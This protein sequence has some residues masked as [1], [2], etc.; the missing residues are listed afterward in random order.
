MKLFKFLLFVGL[1]CGILSGCSSN[2]MP[3]KEAVA[4]QIKERLPEFVA[5]DSLVLENASEKGKEYTKINFKLEARLTEDLF[6]PKKDDVRHGI[7]IDWPCIAVR[8]QRQGEKFFL[9]G[10]LTARKVIDHWEFGGFLFAEGKE[11]IIELGSPF[12]ELEK[13]H[14]YKEGTPEAKAAWDKFEKEN[15]KWTRNNPVIDMHF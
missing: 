12:A 11:K 6:V 15:A 13:R 5:I 2:K 4:N 1:L 10:S 7:L 8:T 9:Y 14:Y 3:P